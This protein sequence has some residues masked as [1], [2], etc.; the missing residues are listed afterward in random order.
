MDEEL[1][2]HDHVAD[3]DGELGQEP[4]P[5]DVSVSSE[6]YVIKLREYIPEADDEHGGYVEEEVG[7]GDEEG[8]ECSALDALVVDDEHAVLVVD[9]RL[10]LLEVHHRPDHP[11]HHRRQ[12]QAVHAETHN[13]FRTFHLYVVRHLPWSQDRTLHKSIG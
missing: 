8:G 6:L 2:V 12:D 9:A 10:L 4:S 13:R 1:G 5:V 3:K 11:R 7:D